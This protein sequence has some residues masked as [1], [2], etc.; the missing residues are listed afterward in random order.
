MRRPSDTNPSTS[1][2]FEHWRLALEGKAPPA[3]SLAP[4]CGFYRAKLARGGPW[5]PAR[6]YVRQTIDIETGELEAPEILMC[7]INHVIVDMDRHWPWLVQEPITK[8]EYDYLCGLQ[9]YVEAHEPNHPLARPR[10]KMNPLTTPLP[11]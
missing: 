5:V 7:E 11:W 3:E 10:E 6:I 4:E 9:R 8:A 1:P 2:L